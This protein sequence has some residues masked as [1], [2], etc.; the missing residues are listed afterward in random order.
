MKNILHLALAIIMTGMFAAGCKSPATPSYADQF[1]P[2][3]GSEIHFSYENLDPAIASPFGEGMVHPIGK[4]QID[5]ATITLV[6]TLDEENPEAGGYIYAELL[7]GDQRLDK[8]EVASGKTGYSVWSEVRM[9]AIKVHYQAGE[10]G[11]IHTLTTYQV[12]ADSFLQVEH[13]EGVK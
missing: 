2:F 7:D 12:G 1:K 9:P 10:S 5:Q 13:L 8:L 11:E 4:L 3:S 6:N